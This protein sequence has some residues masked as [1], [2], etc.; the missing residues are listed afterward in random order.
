MDIIERITIEE[1]I[2]LNEYLKF[3]NS[4]YEF[5]LI[6]GYIKV[7]DKNIYYYKNVKNNI[8]SL[9]NNILSY[10]INMSEYQE[11]NKIT[12]EDYDYLI[13][14]IHLSDIITIFEIGE[15]NEDGII[16]IKNL[17]TNTEGY[18]YKNMLNMYFYNYEK[19][20]VLFSSSGVKFP[21]I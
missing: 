8:Y 1:Y 21:V 18:I 9:N 10:L 4:L 2:L 17:K 20:S 11:K 12:L 16:K 5:N 13:A 3:N 15:L 14:F 19:K 7:K 6:N